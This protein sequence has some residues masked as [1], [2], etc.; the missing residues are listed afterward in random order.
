MKKKEL[1]K[2]LKECWEAADS[3]REQLDRIWAGNSNYDKPTYPNKKEWIEN[4]LKD[5]D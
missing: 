1:E 3:Y 2:L 5:L 4:K